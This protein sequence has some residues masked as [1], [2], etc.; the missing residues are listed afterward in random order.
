MCD[1]ESRRYHQ[2]T[3]LFE[4]LLL[5]SGQTASQQFIG[6]LFMKKLLFFL[7]EIKPVFGW[8]CFR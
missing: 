4:I 7:N 1:P 5:A 2:Q 6:H 8:Y 3:A